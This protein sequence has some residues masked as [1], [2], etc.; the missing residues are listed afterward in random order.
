MGTPF[1]TYQVPYNQQQIQNY[2]KNQQYHNNSFTEQSSKAPQQDATAIIEQ[3]Q[4]LL[5]PQK[6]SVHQVNE[7]KTMTRQPGTT[8]D[9][10]AAAELPTAKSTQE[11]T[12]NATKPECPLTTQDKTKQPPHC[13]HQ[14]AKTTHSSSQSKA[15][16]TIH[17]PPN[18]EKTKQ[19]NTEDHKGQPKLVVRPT[20]TERTEDPQG[21]KS[22]QEILSVH[23][24]NT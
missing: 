2:A 5:L 7:V 9:L 23:I 14:R 12:S 18:R 13:V 10:K 16:K 6:N 4:Q 1:N 17:K 22:H 20:W 24:D 11:T 19:K 8:W 15:T 3:L 21:Q